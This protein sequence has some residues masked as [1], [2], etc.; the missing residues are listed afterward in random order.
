MVKILSL[1]R[2][3]KGGTGSSK[4]ERRGEKRMGQWSR[5]QVITEL[6]KRRGSKKP[7]GISLSLI[8]GIA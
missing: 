5:K 6:E 7:L 3:E 1:F 8:P 4:V 2:E